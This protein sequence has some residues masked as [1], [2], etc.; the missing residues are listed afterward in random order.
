MADG[1]LT[2]KNKEAAPAIIGQS[3]GRFYCAKRK[4]GCA[5]SPEGRKKK[6]F[7]VLQKIGCF[8]GRYTIK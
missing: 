8:Y 6:L 7:S 4:I 5:N 2:D 3:P 1:G